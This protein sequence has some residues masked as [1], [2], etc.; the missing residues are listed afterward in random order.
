M[1]EP[2]CYCITPIDNAPV[3]SD[4]PGLLIPNC[5]VNV[6]TSGQSQLCVINMTNSALQLPK[7]LTIAIA[8]RVRENEITLLETNQIKSSE[9]N[10]GSVKDY[11]DQGVKVELNHVPPEQKETLQELINKYKHIFASKDIE[12]GK[13]NVVTLQI[14]TKDEEPV[15]QRPYKTP[16]TLRP[17]LEQQLEEM[18]QAGIIRHSSSAYAAPIILVPKKDEGMRLVVDFR[19]LNEKVIKNSYP[20][21]NIE[22]VISQLGGCKYYSKIDMKAGFWQIGIKEEDKHKT[23][24]TCFLG[25]FEFEVMP[26]GLTTSP[27]VF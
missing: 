12:L 23:A 8:E 11:P 22:D 15:K 14:D 3:Y 19:K 2:G 18:L 25:L 10:N 13:T 5:L 21:P 26:F 27:S 17:Q 24:F 16:L 4:F 9:K 7:D 20:L 1:K 6:T